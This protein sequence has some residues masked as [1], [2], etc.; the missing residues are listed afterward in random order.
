MDTGGRSA[1][2]PA[3]R[4]GASPAHGWRGYLVAAFFL[5]LIGLLVFRQFVF[6]DHV[7]LYTD[8]GID[9]VNDSYPC[10]VHLSDYL[11][12]VGFPSW[13]FAVG[14]GQ[15]LSYL[16]GDML[17]DPVV[18]LP[19]RLIANALVYQHLIKILAGGLLFF[20]FLQLRGAGL[21]AALLGSMLLGF[22]S[23]M[24][25]GSCW[26]SSADELVAFA[27]LLL[28]TELALQG[29]R[30]IYLCLAVAFIGLI[31][32]FHL[33]LAALLL[34]FYVPA[35]LL[36]LHQRKPVELILVCLQLGGLAWM[37]VGLAAIVTLNGA[38]AVLSSARGS[39]KIPNSW[40]V[41]QFFQLESGL[42]YLTAVLRTFSNDLAGTADGFRGWENYF[43]A[44][45]NY[46]G[47]VSLLLL[48]QFFA[49]A[50]RRERIVAG[51]FLGL[52][53]VPSILPWFRSLFWLFQGGYYRT[54]SLFTV[55]AL[56][57][58]SMTAFSR[59]AERRAI[60]LR[61]LGLTLFVLLAL[62]YLPIH[63]VSSLVEH[64]VRDSAAIFLSL[65]AILLATGHFW[66]RQAVC[67]WCILILS[68]ME[69]IYFD[70]MT[71]N[72]PT[73]LKSKLAGE[74]A[75]LD[76]GSA[77]AVR[78]LE[79][80]EKS[81]FRITKTWSSGPGSRASLNDAM[82]FGYNGTS[83]YSSFN[84]F[85]YIHFLMAVG[86][87]EPANLV[88]TAQWTP[89]LMGYPLLA[90]FTC[91]KYVLTNNPVPFEAA[92]HYEFVQRYQDAYAFRNKLFL[93]L[94]LVFGHYLPADVFMELPSW[95]KAEA[96]L[97]AVVLSPDAAQKA[98]LVALG[99]DELKQQMHDVAPADAIGRLQ[100]GALAMEAFAPTRLSGIVRAD[101][102]AILVW[103]TPFDAGWRAQLDS[104]AATTIAVNGGLLGIPLPAG[105]H[106]V[107][108]AYMPR[109]LYV[110]AGVSLVSFFVLILSLWRWPRL[111]LP[112]A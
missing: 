69:L 52:I 79:A 110:G 27:L 45:T 83:S 105:S 81:F 38:D 70:S 34:C 9:S 63:A 76:D 20:R 65:Y 60:S 40:S 72:R 39:G 2:F 23:Y 73:V 101:E 92:D 7:L 55:L 33:Y 108:L 82:V 87:I 62:L 17:W 29:G 100:A 75:Y 61:T 8:M 6:G 14:M 57:T 49:G 11:R 5:A 95:A 44:P 86:A 104:G 111:R 30:W 106:H 102:R 22:S 84:N 112:Q 36:E 89:G 35:R 97:H 107:E 1:V 48:P 3:R 56:L 109:F 28:G 18:W 46:A 80:R 41:P 99:L 50:S 42:H 77:E 64:R 78:D 25:M 71:V 15:S 93:P 66:K 53:T 68:A 47:L 67:A 4:D 37:G 19:K 21:S 12:N 90:T 54:L 85:N 16:T 98:G 88:S 31:T 74:V 51:F 58:L 59:Y 94:G 43:E 26:F 24:C 91:E 13:S 10:F 103:Q 96:L 32:V